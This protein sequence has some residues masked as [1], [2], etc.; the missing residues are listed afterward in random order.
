MVREWFAVALGGLLGSVLRHGTVQLFSVAGPHWSFIA[1]LVVNLIGCF[2]IGWLAQWSDSAQLTN[3]WWVVGLRAGVLGGLTTFSSFGLDVVRVW[4]NYR[5][6]FAIA[7]TTSHVALG[8][9][10]VVFGMHIAKS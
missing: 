4:Q 10:A 7:L 9:A 8:I 5:P 6:E 1:T 2:S 3:H